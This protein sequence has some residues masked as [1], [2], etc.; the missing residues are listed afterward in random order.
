M[1][2]YRPECRIGRPCKTCKELFLSDDEMML[3]CDD[4]E[5]SLSL[6]GFWG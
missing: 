3:Y 4:S 1:T 6:S 5:K 2:C